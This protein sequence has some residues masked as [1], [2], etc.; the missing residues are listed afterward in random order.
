MTIQI[1]ICHGL[2]SHLKVDVCQVEIV[3]AVDE[4]FN[5]EYEEIDF[6]NDSSSPCDTA[7]RDKHAK[8]DL[9][10]NLRPQF[11]SDASLANIFSDEIVFRDF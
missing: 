1:G 5:L 9:T 11:Q 3:N 10:K 2:A 4:I 8:L 6:Y 7:T